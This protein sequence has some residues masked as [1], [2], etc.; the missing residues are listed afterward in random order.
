[1]LSALDSLQP[2]DLLRRL[3]Q[4]ITFTAHWQ[5]HQRADS[6]CRSRSNFIGHLL[7][8]STT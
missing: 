5:P 8:V 6:E 1:M 3:T 4:R 7:D 2:A